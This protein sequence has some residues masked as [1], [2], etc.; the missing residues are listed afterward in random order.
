[1][2]VLT[3]HMK[4]YIFSSF[5][6]DVKSLAQRSFCIILQLSRAQDRV[7]RNKHILFSKMVKK[8]IDDDTLEKKTKD[9]LFKNTEESFV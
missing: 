8:G 3:S 2:K 9:T 4:A 7:V 1:M 6:S 5:C